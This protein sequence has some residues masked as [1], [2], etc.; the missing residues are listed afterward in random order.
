MQ[1]L[2]DS[3]SIFKK[4]DLSPLIDEYNLNLD[5]KNDQII[6]PD[7]TIKRLEKSYQKTMQKRG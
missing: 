7:S 5:F 2:D 4:G 6:I 3:I 1:K